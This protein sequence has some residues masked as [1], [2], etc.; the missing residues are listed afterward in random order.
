MHSR[1]LLWSGVIVA[2]LG[3]VVSALLTLGQN[4]LERKREQAV[5]NRRLRV[6]VDKIAK[7]DA[8]KI[9]IDPAAQ[10]ILGGAELP[11]YV[12]RT[13]D[14][15][16]REAIE[17]GL[18][19]GRWFVVVHGP[20]KVGKSRTLFQ[21]LTD[22]ELADELELVAPA[23]ADALRSLVTPGEELPRRAKNVVLWLDDLEPFFIDGITWQTL[24]EWHRRS[25]P[26]AI[27]VATYGGKGGRPVPAEHG[28][29]LLTIVTEAL[30]QAYEVSLATS[31]PA[32]LQPLKTLPAETFALIEEHGLA[33]FL[34]AAPALDRKFSTQRH[35]L[36]DPE[37]PEGIAVVRAA[38]DWARCGR[39]DPIERTTLRD[40]W[41]AYLPP[42]VLPTDEGFE[43]GLDWALRPVAGTIAL[44]QRVA[45]F[46][47]Y[48][49]IVQK[50]FESSDIAAPSDVAWQHAVN[51]S[52]DLEALF[53]GNMAYL[54]GRLDQAVLSFPRAA[55][56]EN[57]VVAVDALFNLGRALDLLGRP[58]EALEAY[59]RLI[60]RFGKASDFWFRR[61]VARASVNRG[62]VLR[63]LG[64][65]E[66]AIE[67]YD[68]V[69]SRFDRAEEPEL[70]EQVAM[71]LVNK[72]IAF[73]TSGRPLEALAVNDEVL[74]R[75]GQTATPN[76]SELIATTLV[77]K[78]I[79]LNSL[80]RRREALSV[81]DETLARFGQDEQPKL[82][83]TIATGMVN[84]GAVLGVLDRP[85]DWLR[86]CDDVIARWSQAEDPKLR[87]PVARAMLFRGFALGLLGRPQDQLAAYDEVVGQ[88]ADADE[89]EIRTLVAAALVQKGMVLR[90]Q[91]QTEASLEV[92]ASAVARFENS[93]LP[94]LHEPVAQALL[95][96]GEALGRLGRY[97][98]E[99][100]TYAALS[101]QFG[102]SVDP[103]IRAY[104]AAALVNAGVTLLGLGRLDEALGAFE[105]VLSGFDEAESAAVRE[106]I[107]KALM[108]KGNAL[109]GLGRSDDQRRA[110]EEV[111]ARFEQASEP[112]V[113]VA[114]VFAEVNRA[115]MLNAQGKTESALRILD[116]ALA[117][118]GENPDLRAMIEPVR[119]A[120]L[121][122]SR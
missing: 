98:E 76:M 9:G 28:D 73:S 7:I 108:N 103:D 40:L 74:S 51:T 102:H 17:Q 18:A 89:S 75:F 116:H 80:G 99:L 8:T 32:E 47:A 5:L 96:K 115:F 100:N 94:E 1:P 52:S 29:L 36:G 39:V 37:C 79:L 50:L 104:L 85:E 27:V 45:S 83:P 41:P 15:S 6:S 16:L 12:P 91:G 53:V 14:D 112:S 55:N 117:R 81:Y 71:A 63:Q 121:D 88:Y 25:A 66:D 60:E 20:S 90:D 62:V 64:R 119:Q 4:L 84:R 72:A 22:C 97:E 107:A 13:V 65:L 95:Y 2:L 49:Y 42:T 106:Q 24:E 43:K 19:G 38:V 44:L 30:Q 34:V 93:D 61:A 114:V 78:A 21:A 31:S 59:G 92:L 110:Y 46:Q 33:A 113:L 48:D 23:N 57:D 56:S 35:A 10:D 58:G 26:G 3:A 87:E 69:A 118:F 82:Q 120:L 54:W 77:N 109:G 111:V 11:T 101:N 122:S 68:D 105:S 86:D 67:A 70:Q